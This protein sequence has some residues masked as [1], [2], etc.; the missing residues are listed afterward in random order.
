MDTHGFSQF[1]LNN[2]PPFT[3]EITD[4]AAAKDMAQLTGGSLVYRLYEGMIAHD[5]G[6]DAAT[7]HL[8]ML[9]DTG[10]HYGLL[11]FVVIL[12]D[13]AEETL[14]ERFESMIVNPALV[15]YLSGAF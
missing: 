6:M 8:E 10:N 15:P 9:F 1:V 12:C 13:A 5:Y 7:E 14:P 3:D 11:Y 2:K 4:E